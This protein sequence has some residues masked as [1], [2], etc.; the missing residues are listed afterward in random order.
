MP[1]VDY[2][3][4]PRRGDEVVSTGHLSREQ[5]LEVGDRLK[6]HARAFFSRR[7]LLLL[8]FALELAEDLVVAAAHVM[9]HAPDIDRRETAEG[10]NVNGRR[11]HAGYITA[12]LPAVAEQGRSADFDV[13]AL[14]HVEVEIAED[15][16]N[17]HDGPRVIDLG[18]AEIQVEITES[19][20]SECLA[21]ES[22]SAASR[23]M[24]E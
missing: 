1:G 11:V 10:A 12:P 2:R 5:L 18:F 6:A 3:Y 20:G 24:T 21:S 14:G 16:K 23:D 15:N 9:R 19:T 17:G 7:K 8:V 4:E 13:D 22:Y